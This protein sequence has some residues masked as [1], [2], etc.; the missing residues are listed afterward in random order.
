MRRR[1]AGVVSRVAV[2][3]AA[4]ACG[5]CRVDEAAEVAEY[6]EVLDGGLAPLPRE[7]EGEA[8]DAALDV[9]TAMRLANERNE[10]LAIEGEAYLRALVDRR[11]AAAQWLPVVR[12]SPSYFVRDADDG[13]DSG[14]DVPVVATHDL[15]VRG[16]IA[17]RERAEIEVERRLS[18]LYE[19]QDALL[20]DVG[21]TMYRVLLAERSA[22][23][24]R[25]SVA[26]QEA[27]VEDVRARRD[28]GF[29]RPLDVSLS[30]SSLANARVALIEAESDTRTGRALLSFLTGADLGERPLDG[31]LELPPE[32]E[33]VGELV[34]RALESREEVRAAELAVAGAE[35]VVRIASSQRW[36]ALS[37]D[38]A[39]FLSRDSAPTDSDW[40]GLLQVHL[41]LFTGGRIQADVRDALSLLRETAERRSQTRRAVR[42]DV[43]VA[44]ENLR[45]SRDRIDELRVRLAASREASD[46]AEGLYDAGLATNLERLTAQDDELQTELQ[47][48]RAEL[49][50]KVFY[51]DLLRTTGALHP[52]VGLSRRE[53]PRPDADAPEERRAE[54][55]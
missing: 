2:A 11:R 54:A 39:A 35:Q 48:E 6:R 41:P 45:A 43:E 1:A 53:P 33:G 5:A 24:L 28:V 15:E 55:R 25:S 13:T 38:L 37:L 30:E 44:Y 3:L 4:L 52:W 47:L 22:G 16:T 9:R 14:V 40:S 51:L 32:V 10:S 46:Q 23:V 17:N 21:R 34:E 8:P 7:I 19:T 50:R 18:L 29:A 27:R 20:L 36:P 31:W 49:E 42:R 12:L 26:V